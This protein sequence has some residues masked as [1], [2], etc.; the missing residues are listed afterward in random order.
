MNISIDSDG[1]PPGSYTQPSD[2]DANNKKR[3]FSFG[4]GR[5]VIFQAI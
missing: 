4:Y 5:E 3:G 1:P 2:F